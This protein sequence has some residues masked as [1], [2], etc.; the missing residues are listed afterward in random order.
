[1]DVLTAASKPMSIR[2]AAFSVM[3]NAY[4]HASGDGAWWAEARQVYYAARP[5][6]LRLAQI[7]DLDSGRFIQEFL[8]DYM[9][10]RPEWRVAFDDRGHLV[11]PHTGLEIGLGT[12]AV[13]DYIESY[14]EP[15]SIEGGFAG[16]HIVTHGPIGRYGGILYIEKE[17]FGELL[18]QVQ[19]GKRF[20]LTIMSCKGMSVVAARTVVDRTCA[21]Y[22]IPLF[23]LHDF[24]IAGFSIASTL[25]QTNRRFRFNTKSG[26]DFRVVDFG[27]RLVDVE[28]LRLQSE[29]VAL[30]GS[31]DK[32]RRR[33]EINGALPDEI[34]FLL[35]GR[36][37][38]L[39]ALTSP[40]FIDLLELKVAEH[41]VGKVIPDARKLADAYRLFIRSEHAR[42]VVEEALAAMPTTEI[43]TPADLAER[44]RA[45]LVEHPEA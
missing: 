37:V 4:N 5:D 20:D 35:S 8:V 1:M 23:I 40:Q 38:E 30:K 33:L 12:V 25:H 22:G 3:A 19:I 41:G 28:R 29:P 43:A 7:D 14:A 15:E 27:L 9:N 36:R 31:L 16:A 17:G 21:R 39:N 32:K 13:K 11:E 10:G 6:V 18:D 34:E 24:D 45:Y 26:E 2:D 44:V 42:R